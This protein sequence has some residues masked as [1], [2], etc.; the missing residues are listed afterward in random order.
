MKDT[1][2][3]LGQIND[4]ILRQFKGYRIWD[5]EITFP[6]SSKETSSG[7]YTHGQLTVYATDS[8][9]KWD[10]HSFEFNSPN[11]VSSEL[12][13]LLDS[14]VYITLVKNK[15]IVIWAE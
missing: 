10:I 2:T 13:E 15:E 12:R 6:Q 9:G 5:I 3:F 7:Y 1:S 8:Q 14:S 11:K 4:F